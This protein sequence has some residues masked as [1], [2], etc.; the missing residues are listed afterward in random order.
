MHPAVASLRIRFEVVH[1][2]SH[3]DAVPFRAVD[4]VHTHQLR[5]VVHEPQATAAAVPP[6]SEQAGVRRQLVNKV[7]VSGA[8]FRRPESC[9]ASHSRS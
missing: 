3:D 1:S 6:S 5:V 9:Q 4:P 8:F 2:D 7:S